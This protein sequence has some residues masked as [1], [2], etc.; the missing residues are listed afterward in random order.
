MT[1][2]EIQQAIRGHLERANIQADEV[3]V[4]ADPYGGWRIAVVAPGFEELSPRQRRDSTLGG[5]EKTLEI[6]WVDL[7]TPEEREWAGSLPAETE[8]SDLPLWPEA[9]ARG[10]SMLAAPRFPSDRDEDLEPPIVATFYSLRGGVGRST[11][12]AYT[13]RILASHGH[14]VVCVDMDLEAPGLAALFGQEE[15]IEKDQG[16]VALLMALDQGD[17]P[18]FA[19]HLLRVEENE[20]L[21]LVPAGLPGPDYARRLRF[22][23]P[24]TWYQ[25]DP[26]PLRQLLAGLREGLPFRPDVILFDARTGITPLSGPLLFDLADLAI[27]TFFPHPQARRGTEVLVRGL[28]AASTYRGANGQASAPE[29]RFLVSPIPASKAREVIQRYEHRSLTWISD[30]LASANEGREAEG[31]EPLN[32]SDVTH[33][34]R[35]REDVATSDR[36]L[37]DTEIWRAFEPV[38][39]WI[40]GFLATPGE[41]RAE[42][43]LEKMKSTILQELRF[44]SGTAETQ[45]DFLRSFVKTEVVQEA[46]AP[47]FPL[48][49][50]RKGSGKTALF[51]FLSEEQADSTIVVHAPADLRGKSDWLLS[52]DGFKAVDEL[53]GERAEWRHFWAFYACVSAAHHLGSSPPPGLAAHLDALPH[54]ERAML[55]SFEQCLDVPRFALELND[56]LGALGREATPDTLLLLDGL[57]TGFGSTQEDRER[58]RRAIEQLFDLW[59]ERGTKLES[60]R[61]KIVLREDIWRSL[62]FENKSHLYGRSVALQWKDQAAYFKVALKQALNSSG[63]FRGLLEA[64]R[65]GER[66]AALDLEEW[67]GENVFT[68]WKLLVGERMKGGKSAFTRNWIWNRLGDANFDHTPRHLLQLFHESVPWERKEHGQS[69]YHRSV[70]RPRGLIKCLPQVSEQALEALREEFSE[71]QELMDRLRRFGRTPVPAEELHGHEAEVELAREVGL[72]SVYEESGERVER[73]KVPDLFRYGLDMAR[74][75]QA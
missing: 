17:E 37:K 18:D 55:N 10:G 21:Y 43:S 4:Q 29:P 71:L 75:G 35:Y 39:D 62:R 16:V 63:A 49:L 26:N 42:L 47:D 59:M 23:E 64:T 74:K 6:E 69:A 53:L 27:V 57:D 38:G 45:E 61:F 50:G 72:L 65:G 73:Y 7:L 24:F 15:Q 5:L 12:L 67:S 48:V 28:L 60:L 30:W 9:L 44:A 70:V 33:F 25:E 68:A 11:A 13:A 66:L 3:R 1:R 51:R 2:E 34:V 54:S 40:E 58:R 8:L 52:R 56:W 46:L 41:E 19:S 22:L 20:D 31:A 32:E 14:K 36:I